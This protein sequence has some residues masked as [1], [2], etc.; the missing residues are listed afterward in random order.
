MMNFLYFCLFLVWLPWS[1]SKENYNNACDIS[2]KWQYGTD[3][4]VLIYNY[5]EA[6]QQQL[7]R[8]RLSCEGKCS[9]WQ[10]ATGNISTNNSFVIEFY[11][12]QRAPVVLNGFVS[13]SCAVMEFPSANSEWTRV[14][15]SFNCSCLSYPPPCNWPSNVPSSSPFEN[16]PG[17][18]YIRIG[19]GLVHQLWGDTLY[20]S[21]DDDGNLYSAYDDGAGVGSNC[22]DNNPHCN[23]STTGNVIISG[24]DWRNLTLTKMPPVTESG[25]PYNGRYT[26]ANIA[27][28]GVW[29]VGTYALGD[30]DLECEYYKKQY[31]C[32]Q[33]CNMGPF[34]GFR[35]STDKGKTW[36]EP[37]QNTSN[38]LFN[39]PLHPNGVV[40]M[41][42][43]HV[44]DYGQGNKHSP[45]GKVY[46]VGNGCL[47][48]HPGSNC[49]WISGDAV[50]MAR[51]TI[52]PKQ[53][54]SIND[55]SNWEFWTGED[56]S[57]NFSDIKPVWSWMYKVGTV[58]ITF[59]PYSN[60]YIMCVTTPSADVF[61]STVAQYDT[62]FLESDSI[63]GKYKMISYLERFGPQA[64]FVHWPSKFISNATAGV[65]MYSA[66]FR[67]MNKNLPPNPPGSGYG[68]NV[69]PISIH[70]LT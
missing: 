42:A 1:S 49:S 7:Q 68:L 48:T 9:A 6:Q 53:P 16:A 15:S 64:Y 47:Q 11:S 20:P 30:F 39:E 3:V 58:T 63:T 40:K 52:N 33:F 17:N 55:A 50:F 41:G 70:T 38:N 60:K 5:E 56:W 51:V 57:S 14:C 59:N 8:F 29:W 18:P 37:S 2:G 62:Y 35:Y 32:L 45:D 13:P 21:W 25:Y 23:T 26:S 12:T 43:P 34:I 65:L 22:P 10:H 54:Q 61:P 46:I 36:T 44:V 31:A 66:N 24:H 27:L 4:Y 67:Q 28:G 69:V 19:D